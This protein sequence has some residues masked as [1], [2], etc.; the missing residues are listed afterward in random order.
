M[1]HFTSGPH[2][3]LAGGLQCWTFPIQACGDHTLDGALYFGT[4]ISGGQEFLFDH[5]HSE[6]RRL[7]G[8]TMIIVGPGA[9]NDYYA[10]MAYKAHMIVLHSPNILPH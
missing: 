8:Y 7:D 5:H 4:S 3:K 10:G 2:T 1:V 9:P 6:V